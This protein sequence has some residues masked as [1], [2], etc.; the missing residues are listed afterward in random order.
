MNIK[1]EPIKFRSPYN[2][3]G[4]IEVNRC[5]MFCKLTPKG[6]W[7]HIGLDDKNLCKQLVQVYGEQVI[8]AEEPNGYCD[9]IKG[10]S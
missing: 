1:V 9:S 4:F 10:C 7:R 6:Q 2:T 8:A 3:Y 5:V